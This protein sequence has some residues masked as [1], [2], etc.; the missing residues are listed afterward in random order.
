MFFKIINFHVTIKNIFKKVK[1]Y[2]KLVENIK[3]IPKYSKV[4][5]HTTTSKRRQLEPNRRLV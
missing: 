2:I 3:L 1:R 4:K 5:G